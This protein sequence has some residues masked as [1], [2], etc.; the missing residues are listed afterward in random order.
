MI[1]L[2]YVWISRLPR[3]LFIA[4]CLLAVEGRLH[5]QYIGVTCGWNYGGELVGPNTG[6]WLNTPLFNPNPSKPNLSWSDWV[7]ELRASGV[8]FV[9]PNLRGG[10]SQYNSTNLPPLLQALQEHGMSQRIK[11]AIFDDNASSWAAFG[12][13]QPFD[14][15]NTNNWKYIWD[16][17]YKPFYDTIPDTNRF[18][19]NGRP[20][21]IVWTG[22]T[23]FITNM[24]GN[25]SKAFKYV[26]QQCQSTFGFNPFIIVSA[27]FLSNDTTMNDTNVVDATESWFTPNSSHGS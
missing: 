16:Q 17:N 6:T 18:K 14:I 4:V 1:A 9:C 11:V 15:A 7:E 24:Q 13:G 8:D 20:V 25:A 21:I 3:F 22:N 12:G 23:Y 2:R 10:M 5:A 27:D 19:I 26:R